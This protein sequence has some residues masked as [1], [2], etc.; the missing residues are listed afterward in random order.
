MQD[1]LT[2]L[3]QSL[4]EMRNSYSGASVERKELLDRQIRE[5]EKMEEQL[6]QDIQQLEKAIRYSENQLINQ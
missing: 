1:Q 3:K 2:Q 6:R 4:S 5:N